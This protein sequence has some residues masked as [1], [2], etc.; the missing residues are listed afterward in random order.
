[1]EPYFLYTEK[2]AIEGKVGNKKIENLKNMIDIEL[3]FIINKERKKFIDELDNYVKIDIQ[4]EPMMI[5]G[6][7][8]IGKTITL[9]LYTILESEEYKKIYFNLKLLETYNPRNYLFIELMKAFIDLNNEDFLEYI[10][11]VSKFQDI[12]ISD[13]NKFFE[14]LSNIFVFSKGF[15][16]IDSL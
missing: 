10:N 12:K 6:N 15:G 2:K 4:E 5:I 8:G 7:D 9:Q 11:C 13:T 14:I 3:C 16:D 1:M